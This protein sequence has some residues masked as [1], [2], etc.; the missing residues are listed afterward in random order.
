MP[1][2]LITGQTTPEEFVQAMMDNSGKVFRYDATPEYFLEIFNLIRSLKGS[3][4]GATYKLTNG[5]LVRVTNIP[6]EDK[7]II[8]KATVRLQKWDSGKEYPGFFEVACK[9]YPDSVYIIKASKK[10]GWSIGCVEPT[11]DEKVPAIKGTIIAPASDIKTG[12]TRVNSSTGKTEEEYMR[13]GCVFDFGNDIP[14]SLI[15]SMIGNNSYDTKAHVIGTY[16][17]KRSPGQW[18]PTVDGIAKHIHTDE[19]GQLWFHIGEY[20]Q[21]VKNMLC[22][23]WDERLFNDGMRISTYDKDYSGLQGVGSTTMRI[24]GITEDPQDEEVDWDYFINYSVE[25]R[26]SEFYWVPIDSGE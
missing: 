14:A 15:Q 18:V 1:K 22:D 20:F 10:Y 13:L 21:D 23:K 11:L 16:K 7:Y 9:Y 8:N 2:I 4:P 6:S 3:F 12:K 19:N 25:D 17:V 5:E 26:Y 24:D